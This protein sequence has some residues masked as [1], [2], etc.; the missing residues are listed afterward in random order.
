MDLILGSSS[1]RKALADHVDPRD[2]EKD[3]QEDL[4]RFIEES[5]SFYLYE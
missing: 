2:L 3:W 4:N 5:K 1:I